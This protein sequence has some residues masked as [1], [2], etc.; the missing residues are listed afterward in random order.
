MFF[1]LILFSNKVSIA[2]PVSKQI[3]YRIS[4][5]AGGVALPG[6][7]IPIASLIDAIVFAVYIPA[8]DP[9]KGQATF[10]RVFN[11]SKVIFPALYVPTASY[12]SCIVTDFPFQLPGN[13]VPP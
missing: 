11:S 6:R 4:L 13:I 5:S 2:F 8:H 7:D 1:G 3:L 10:S 9:A 12:T